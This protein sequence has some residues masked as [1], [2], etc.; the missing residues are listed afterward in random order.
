MM[1]IN[2][3][4]IMFENNKIKYYSTSNIYC[5]LSEHKYYKSD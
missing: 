2:N 4:N 1:N 3:N 5:N